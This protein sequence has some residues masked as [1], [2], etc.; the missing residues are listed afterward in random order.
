MDAERLT[1]LLDC[2]FYTGVPDSQLKPLCDFLYCRYGTDPRRHAVAANEG[3]AAALAAGYYLSTGKV[4]AV[5][6]QNSGLGNFVNPAAS[7]LNR[8]VYGIPCLLLVGWR[9]EPGVPDEPQHIFQGEI[10][11]KQLELLEIPFLVLDRA[12]TEGQV[13]DRL[14]EY[15]A[16]FRQG[17][18]AAL[19]VRRGGL[20]W[21]GQAAYGSGYSMLREDAIA[22]IARAAGEDIVVSSTGKIS[23]E[24]Y[25]VRQARGQGHEKDFLTVGSMGHC[26]SIALGIA[27]HRPERRVWCLDGDGAA[28]MHLGAMAA[29]GAARPENLVHIV[30]NNRAHESVGGMPTAAGSPDWP[31]IARSCGYPLAEPVSGPEELEEALARA[32]RCGRLCF[33]EVKCALGARAGLGR[34]ASSPEENR[35][36]LMAELRGG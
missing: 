5:Y 7:L 26:S 10:T 28:L 24:L 14:A 34:P 12:V 20:T 33:L 23:R 13:R 4:P 21:S 11:P 19:L 2:G 17:R 36:A 25:E 31:G 3:A 30:L 1:E 27:L 29:V 32:A 16:L 35:R 22:R 8:R 18:Q 9:G 6:L 15:R